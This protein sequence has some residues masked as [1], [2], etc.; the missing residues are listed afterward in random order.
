MLTA[1]SAVTLA[2]LTF[3]LPVAVV[4]IYL[5]A[6]RQQCELKLIHLNQR[7]KDVFRITKLDKIFEGHEDMLGMTPD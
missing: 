4:S 5:S 7:L 3:A 1:A 6:R 2:G